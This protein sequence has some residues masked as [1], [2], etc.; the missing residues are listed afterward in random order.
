MTLANLLSEDRVIAEM[1]ANEQGSAIAELV[2]RLVETSV[3][4]EDGRSPVLD[5]LKA[6]EEDRSTGIG[7]GVAIPHCFSEDIEDVALVFGRSTDGIDFFSVDRSL[8]HFIVLFVVPKSEYALHLKT[9]AAIAKILNSAETRE[10]LI[11]AKE[12]SELHDILTKSN[13]SV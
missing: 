3:L 4:P 9:L 12:V 7:N 2:D 11:E 6:R 8:V 1:T 13:S 5:A 10:Q